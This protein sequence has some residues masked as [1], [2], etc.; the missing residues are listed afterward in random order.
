VEIRRKLKKKILPRRKKEI[1]RTRRIK[2]IRKIR[3][4]ASTSEIYETINALITQ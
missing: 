2:S 1:K 4:R 3:R